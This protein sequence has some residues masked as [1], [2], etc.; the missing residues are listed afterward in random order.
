MIRWA[1]TEAIK[2]VF[3]PAAKLFFTY[4]NLKASIGSNFEALMAG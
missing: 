2:V 1:I 3:L 4:S